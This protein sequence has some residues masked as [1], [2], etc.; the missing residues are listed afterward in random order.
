MTAPAPPVPVAV[1]FGKRVLA[2]RTKRGWSRAGMASRSGLTVAVLR[3]IERG[4]NTTLAT[5][6]KVAGAFRVPLARLL[7]PVTCERCL[8][9]APPRGFACPACGTA[10]AKV[11][12]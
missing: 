3:R 11:P 10:E 2:L 5:A 8:D 1:A 6:A 12:G 7:A 4:E 9:A